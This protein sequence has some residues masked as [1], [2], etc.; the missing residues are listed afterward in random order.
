MLTEFDIELFRA[1][2]HYRLY[3]KMGS[4][5]VEVEGEQGCYFAVYA[6]AAQSVHVSGDFNHWNDQA[7]PLNV[8]WDG[9]GIW[10]GLIPGEL[11]GQRYK[12]VIRS[13]YGVF[14]K[15][16]PF[17]RFWERPPHTASIIWQQD[18]D[19]QDEAWMRERH[20]RNSLSSPMSV[21]EMHAG[22]WRWNTE[23]GRPLN[24]REMAEQLPAYIND[25]G[26]THVEFMPVMEYPYDPSWGYQLTGYFAPTS[27]F[28]SPEDFRFLVDKL[29]QAGIG[30]ILDWVPSHF[31][32]DEHGLASFD[33][34]AVYEHPDPRKG[35]HP[36]WKSMIFNYGR[37]EVRSF[38]VSNA[39]FWLDQF[40]ADGLRVDAVASMLYLD[41]SRNDGEWEPNDFGGRENLDA[42]GFLQDLNTAVYSAYPD[43]QTIA[44]ESTAFPGV[45]RPVDAGGLGFGLKWM[46]GWMHDSL[47]Y[48]SKD[49]VHRKYHQNEIT[50]SLAYAFTENFMLPLS[51]DEVVYG[52]KSMLEKMPGDDWQKFANLRLFYALMYA[53]PGSKLLFMGG[54][55][56]Q[57]EEWNFS[58]SLDW[59]LAGKEEHRGIQMTLRRLNHLY[60]GNT[61]LHRLAYSSEGFEWIDFNDSAASVISFVRMDGTGNQLIVSANLTPAPRPAYRIGVPGAGQ[62]NLLFNSDDKLLGGSGFNTSN[63]ISTE[64]KSWHGRD[65][66]AVIDLPPLS[67]LFFELTV[68][69]IK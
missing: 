55:F 37:P 56:G 61:C 13:A 24:W 59:H 25:L 3:E 5:M 15:G 67:C 38:L 23:D 9:S 66:S 62:L 57:R 60:A 18:Y 11:N 64:D 1:G 36:D 22:S 47:Q 29:H 8:R 28:G 20:K 65:H 10:E 69:K 48:F 26:F 16:D 19:W 53:H 50:F 40:H 2:K 63:L 42:I 44:E 32:A 54:E 12:Y 45:T 4:R 41:Y 39:L 27:R 35:Y 33:G 30:V 7:H 51:H 31:P 46:M 68:K 17:A 58:K 14:E 21:Y 6:P 52:K 43:V 34:T 49:P